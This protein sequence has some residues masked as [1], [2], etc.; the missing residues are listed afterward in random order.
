[1]EA[2]IRRLGF[3][4][5][6]FVLL[7]AVMALRRPDIY[8]GNG[9]VSEY[10]LTPS[11]AAVFV[12]AFLGAA[13]SMWV[14]AGSFP[15]TA[16]GKGIRLAFRLCAVLTIGLVVF[17]AIGDGFVDHLHIWIAIVLFTVESLLVICLAIRVGCCVVNMTL[18]TILLTAALAS[19][20][21]L[22]HIVHCKTQAE[23]LFQLAFNLLLSR[24]LR[25]KV[26]SS[27]C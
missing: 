10:A 13:V 9:G 1:M 19:L 20:A 2:S 6:V 22:Y 7:L 18:L 25:G 11:T 27:E 21:S 24:L 17:P 8:F 3:G 26:P 12:A 4:Q 5:I 15:A 23:I 16:T 14:V